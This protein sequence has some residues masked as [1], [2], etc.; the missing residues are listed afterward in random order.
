MAFTGNEGNPINLDVARKWVQNY[1]KKE[2]EDAIYAQFFGCDTINKILSQHNA[3]GK[4]KG[5]RIY[6]GI[7]EHGKS[8]L[9]LVG[10]TEDEN[11]MLPKNEGPGLQQESA[12]NSESGDPDDD[13]I[14]V[15][16]GIPCPQNCGSGGL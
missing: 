5:L 14:V 3:D 13:P 11:N 7:D 9:I 15:N 1:R 4:C 16:D 6:Q 12:F 10:A 2:G 8:H